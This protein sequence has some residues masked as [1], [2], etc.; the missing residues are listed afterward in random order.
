MKPRS[1]NLDV[2]QLVLSLFP[3]V[4]LLD[5]A[6]QEYGFC[7][8]RGPDLIHGAEKRDWRFPPAGR[9]D[10]I[11]AG[12][13]CQGF[14][15]ANS[16][17]KNPDHPSVRHSQEM[18]QLVATIIDASRPRWALVENVPSVPELRIS[19][20]TTQRIHINDYECGGRQLRW[21]AVQWLHSDGWHLRPTRVNDR[22][23]S[24]RKGR[25]PVAVTT[26]PSSRHMTYAEQ[27]RRQGLSQVLELPG[28]SREARF[29]AV[30]NGVPLSVGRVLAAAVA[31][32]DASMAD[33]LR[34]GPRTDRDCGCGC[35]REVAG[36]RQRCATA[37]CR[38]RL[39]LARRKTEGEQ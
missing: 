17:R 37:A 9:I 25:R 1:Q 2:S 21:R 20:Y 11:I 26:K 30:G 18:L 35:G 16:Q 33:S 6:F 7:V 5:M 19:G 8:V 24:R 32:C 4:G 38:K 3:G 28:W 14:S 39:Q 29:R 10:G 13:P 36:G 22:S 34:V 23:G 31:E 27:C 15:C 12:P